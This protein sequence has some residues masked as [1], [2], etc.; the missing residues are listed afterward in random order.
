MTEALDAPA[1]RLDALD[2]VGRFGRLDLRHPAHGLEHFGQALRVECL[3]ALVLAD[4]VQGRQ[5]LGRD[6][7]PS[8]Y[9]GARECMRAPS[10]DGKWI[11]PPVFGSFK[12][13]T[14]YLSSVLDHCKHEMIQ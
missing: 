11:T 4:P 10:R 3:L 7:R 9:V 14:S 12:H 1:G 2:P 13:H 5:L 8:R 6:C